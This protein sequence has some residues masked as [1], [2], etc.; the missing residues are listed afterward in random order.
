MIPSIPNNGGPFPETDDGN[1]YIAVVVDYFSKW[2]DTYVLPNQEASTAADASITH[3]IYLFGVPLEVHS[4]Q[5]TN[6]ELNLFQ[7]VCRTFNNTTTTKGT[8]N[9]FFTYHHLLL[10][11]YRSPDHE[12]TGQTPASIIMGREL[13][14]LCDLKFGCTPGDDV[15]G[16]NYVSTLC[17]RVRSS[18][19][20]ASDRMKETYSVK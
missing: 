1:K 7:N 14:F 17:Q 16:E 20:R 5:G 12:K 19:Q 8:G 2:V 4:D 6:V 10:L 18:I 15:A 3:W 11:A 13:R 9:S